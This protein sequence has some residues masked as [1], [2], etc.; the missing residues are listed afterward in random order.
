MDPEL[1]VAVAVVC[2]NGD[3]L[4]AAG[5]VSGQACLLVWQAHMCSIYCPASW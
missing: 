1:S 2:S 4:Y 3:G 5:Y